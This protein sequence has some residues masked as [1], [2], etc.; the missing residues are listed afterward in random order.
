M[1][2]TKNFRNADEMVD[3]VY[4]QLPEAVV[5]FMRDGELM[6]AVCKRD[7]EQIEYL[8]K[9]LKD[10]CKQY[11]PPKDFEMYIDHALGTTVYIRLE[12]RL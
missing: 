8:D 9:N 12:E 2:E 6:S 7:W 5:Y 11:K 4:K 1:M 3:E 10:L